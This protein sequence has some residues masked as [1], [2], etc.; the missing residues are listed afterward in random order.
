MLLCIIYNALGILNLSGK[1]GAIHSESAR[2]SIAT[3]PT[4]FSGAENKEIIIL[5]N[6]PKLF[7]V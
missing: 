5:T 7:K 2:G 4:Y 3:N 1:G 6:W